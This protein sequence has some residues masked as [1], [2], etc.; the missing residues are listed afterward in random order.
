MGEFRN[1]YVSKNKGMTAIQTKREKKTK[2]KNKKETKYKI[3]N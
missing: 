2:K 3:K 1:F